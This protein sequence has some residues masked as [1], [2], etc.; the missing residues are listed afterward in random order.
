MPRTRPRSA[1]RVIVVVHVRRPLFCSAQV[2]QR[3]LLAVIAAAWRQLY[4]D[5]ADLPAQVASVWLVTRWS[6][7][8]NPIRFDPQ[9]PAVPATTHVPVTTTH[10]AAAGSAASPPATPLAERAWVALYE[11]Q[12]AA[13]PTQPSAVA[14]M[15]TLVEVIARS[16]AGTMAELRQELLR[17]VAALK[18]HSATHVSSVSS[19]CEL[20]LRF[21]TLRPGD[22]GGSFADFRAKLV[23]AG[24]RTLLVCLFGMVVGFFFF[25]CV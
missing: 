16:D 8:T 22:T 6:Q 5:A 21:I 2:Q 14:A 15:A 3:L 10:V 24:T 12:L 13:D 11:A 7:A 4:G 20:F 17:A 1:G 19:G 23:Q 25:L 18:R 9:L